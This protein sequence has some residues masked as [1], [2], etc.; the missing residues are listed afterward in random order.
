MFRKKKR[1]PRHSI[2]LSGR[3]GADPRWEA[4]ARGCPARVPV[5]IPVAVGAQVSEGVLLFEAVGVG[6][7]G[8]WDGRWIRALRWRGKK[9]VLRRV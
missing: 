1:C 4:R 7:G 9:L 6:E 8:H 5:S 3:G 2:C